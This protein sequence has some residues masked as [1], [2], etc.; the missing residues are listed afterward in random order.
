M[1]IV[2]NVKIAICLIFAAAMLVLP[3]DWAVTCL[4][5]PYRIS[6]YRDTLAYNIMIQFFLTIRALVVSLINHQ[7]I[8]CYLFFCKKMKM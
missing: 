3:L 4:T 2:F 8:P 5:T 7:I 1:P 6:R